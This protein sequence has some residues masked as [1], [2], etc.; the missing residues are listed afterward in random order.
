MLNEYFKVDH[1]TEFEGWNEALTEAKRIVAFAYSKFLRS[2]HVAVSPEAKIKEYLDQ[3]EILKLFVGYENYEVN[4]IMSAA[5]ADHV[6]QNSNK[7]LSSETLAAAE[8][9]FLNL[10]TNNSGDKE[11]IRT[12]FGTKIQGTWDDFVNFCETNF[13]S[14]NVD[15]RI[16]RKRIQELL[17][18]YQ[19]F[20]E[21]RDRKA[22]VDFCAPYS[23]GANKEDKLVIMKN[24]LPI[25]Q[26]FS[27]SETGRLL[28]I[29]AHH[30]LMEQME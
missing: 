26:A 18:I 29:S 16:Y 17:P 13:A 3:S 6:K 11:L 22:F 1:E 12:L 23:V 9:F 21:K 4:E 2:Q 8:Q 20:L 14:V 15:I 19:A 7:W 25:Y 28:W 5:L 27:Q 10:K 24:L 30:I